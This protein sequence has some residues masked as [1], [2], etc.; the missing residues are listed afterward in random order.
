MCDDCSW[1]DAMALAEELA[2][3]GST[4]AQD[5]LNTWF[6]H[7]EHVTE[8]QRAALVSTELAFDARDEGHL[9]RY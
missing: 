9:D 7:V 5:L 3:R 6:D 2:E 8:A 1:E 4:Y